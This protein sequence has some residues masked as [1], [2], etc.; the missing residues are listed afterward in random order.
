MIARPRRPI[1]IRRAASADGPQVTVPDAYTPVLVSVLGQPTFPFLG[2]DGRYH[3]AYDL[4]LTNATNVP[5]TLLKVEVVDGIDPSRVVATFDE[6][7]LAAKDP[8]S[9]KDADC[10]VLRTLKAFGGRVASSEIAPNASLM[11]YVTYSFG[12]LDEAPKVVLHRLSLLGAN[13]P[14]PGDPVPVTQLVTPYDIAA[15]TPRVLGPPVGGTGWVALNGC[16][17]PFFPHVTSSS[18]RSSTWVR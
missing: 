13:S 17:E 2:S 12:S 1:R 18:T 5:A 8:R 4:Q 11:M 16:C 3:V 6:A 7:S 15:G 10:G 14:A 9:C